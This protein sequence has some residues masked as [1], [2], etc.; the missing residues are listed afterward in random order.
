MFKDPA[1]NNQ[2][3]RSDP[4]VEPSKRGVATPDWF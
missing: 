4:G 3:K 1:A 2:A